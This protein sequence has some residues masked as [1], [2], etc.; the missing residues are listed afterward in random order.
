MHARLHGFGALLIVN[1]PLGASQD[2]GYITFE[3]LCGMS[4]GYY[5][6]TYL[7]NLHTFP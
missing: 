7:I 3:A 5:L 4:P 2:A 6:F 1:W